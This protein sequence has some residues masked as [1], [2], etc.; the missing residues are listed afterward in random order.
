MNLYKITRIY[1]ENIFVEG[2]NKKEALDKLNEFGGSIPPLKDLKITKVVDATEL[3]WI[4]PIPA[5]EALKR[6]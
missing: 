5:E 3:P 4:V 1:E 6:F 2:E